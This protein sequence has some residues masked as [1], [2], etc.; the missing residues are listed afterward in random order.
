MKESLIPRPCAIT[1]HQYHVDG[2]LHGLGVGRDRRPYAIVE[3][4]T[5]VKIV[6][7]DEHY[8][9]TFPMEASR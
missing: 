8:G 7:L 2:I 9:I 5:E 3:T 6:H 4:E 1:S